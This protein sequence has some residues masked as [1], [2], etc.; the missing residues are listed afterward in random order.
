MSFV[1]ISSVSGRA[2][3]QF[4]WDRTVYPTE[5]GAKTACIKLNRAQGGI[6]YWHVMSLS[7]YDN[8]PARAKMVEPRTAW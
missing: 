4:Y 2:R 7:D 6:A 5:P 3:G 8:S 1:I